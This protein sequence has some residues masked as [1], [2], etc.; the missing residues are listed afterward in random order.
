VRQTESGNF[1]VILYYD[2]KNIYSATWPELVI[3][4]IRRI[5]IH[6]KITGYCGT[7]KVMYLCDKNENDVKPNK[8]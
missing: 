5:V 6:K 4:R 7:K 1:N 8:R 2:L 3:M